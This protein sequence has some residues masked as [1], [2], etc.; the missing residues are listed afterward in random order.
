MTGNM[1]R[2][3]ELIVSVIAWISGLCVFIPFGLL[4]LSVSLFID[5]KKLDRF[6]KAGCRRIIQFLFI[7]IE[8]EG[9]NHFQKD[10][11]YLFISNHVNLFDPFILYGYIPNFIRGVELDKHFDWIFYGRIIRRMGMIPISHTNMQE[12]LKSLNEAKQRIKD[13]TSIIILPEGGRTLD[14]KF[15]SFKRGAFHLAKETGVD[16]IPLVMVGAYQINRKGSLHIRPG[17]II[18]RFGY[19]IPHQ[20]IKAMEI[21]EISDY[22]R[23]KM[24]DLFNCAEY[25][26]PGI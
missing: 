5:P 24:L 2:S 1:K 8:T 6:I 26:P 4:I 22:I 21:K 18:L 17:K 16:I 3:K 14:G 15:K 9:L 19:P 7:R 20:A 10:K 25:S 13:G 23:S 11:T 12:A